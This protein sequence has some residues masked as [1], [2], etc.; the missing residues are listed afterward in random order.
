[1]K[2]NQSKSPP[3]LVNALT[4][5]VEDY[6]QV[7]AFADVVRREDWPRWESRI[8]RNTHL[9]LDLLA[10]HAVQGTFFILGWI[11]EHHPQLVR[12][13][14]AAGHEVAS[15][16]YEHRLIYRQRPDQFRSDVRRAREILEDLIGARV[17]G[18]RAPSYS[19]TRESLWALD[20]LIEEGFSYDSSIFPVH[21]DRYGMPRAERF[22]HT[23]SRPAGEILEFPPS[24][25]KLLGINL[26]IAGGGYFRLLPYWF[27]RWGLSYINRH[28]QQPVIF[29]VHP[30]EVDP[31]QPVIPGKRFNVWRHRLHLDRTEDRLKQLLAHFRF[32]PVRQLM[33]SAAQ[34]NCVKQSS[35]LSSGQ[36]FPSRASG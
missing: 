24:T 16:G 21:H 36:A 5:D 13:I 7:E 4:V 25:L 19:I 17:E 12:E 1:M 33:R 14:A 34:S 23:I 2:R 20:I 11:A 32:A 30:W 15:H 26:P 27:F 9:I 31:A 29:F 10:R 18:Y 28:E 3:E 6:F 35:D 22:L 8:E